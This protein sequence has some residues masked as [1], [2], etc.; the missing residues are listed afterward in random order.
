MV[1]KA[2]FESTGVVYE[3]GDCRLNSDEQLFGI[4]DRFSSL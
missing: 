1:L 2:V 3:A 4:T